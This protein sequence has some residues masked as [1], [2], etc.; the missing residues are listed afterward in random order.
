MTR[1]SRLTIVGVIVGATLA[2]QASP[3]H[4]NCAPTAKSRV[5]LM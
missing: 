1:F 3:G 2:N 4:M 5:E